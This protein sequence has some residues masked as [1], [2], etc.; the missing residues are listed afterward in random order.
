MTR[1]STSAVELPAGWDF[2]GSG[3]AGCAVPFFSMARRLEY[4]DNLVNPP[5]ALSQPWLHT[6]NGSSRTGAFDPATVSHFH[7]LLAAIARLDFLPDHAGGRTARWDNSLD[8]QRHQSA[9]H[10]AAPPWRRD[11]G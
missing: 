7:F 1:V 10:E 4:A 8:R 6:S 2:A 3:A 5:A 11:C 9:R